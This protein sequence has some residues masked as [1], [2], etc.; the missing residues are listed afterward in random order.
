MCVR[1]SKMIDANETLWQNREWTA[2]EKLILQV[3]RKPGAETVLNVFLRQFQQISISWERVQRSLK[4]SMEGPHPFHC[5]FALDPQRGIDVARSYAS[6]SGLGAYWH[7]KPDCIICC[8]PKGCGEKK[9][10]WCTTHFQLH[11]ETGT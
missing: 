2:S 1:S 9:K 6:E 3:T 10:V 7:Y 11:L 4:R 5:L 8:S